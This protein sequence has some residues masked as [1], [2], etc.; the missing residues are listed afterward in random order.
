LTNNHSRHITNIN[1]H[2]RPENTQHATTKKEK[3]ATFT[4]Y[5]LETRMITR[6]FKNTSI[7]IAFKTNNT[8]KKH[9][10]PKN[11]I[12]DI[13]QKSVV[14]QLKCNECPLRN[15]GQMGCMFKDL[16]REHIQAIRTNKHTSEYAQHILDMGHAYCKMEETMD[17][18]HITRKGHLLN[19]FERFYI[20]MT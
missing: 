15:V 13:Y 2:N 1:Q 18:I 17:I 3:W 10:K 12:M 19:T 16:Y 4:Y 11:Q 20:Y 14:Y 8:I 9:L 6:P 7:G 5:G